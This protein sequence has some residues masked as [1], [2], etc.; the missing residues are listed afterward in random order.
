MLSV[1][2]I[3]GIAAYFGATVTAATP[4]AAQ[5]SLFGTSLSVAG[6]ADIRDRA[7]VRVRTV[8]PDLALIPQ[9]AAQTND[10]AGLPHFNLDLFPGVEFDAEVLHAEAIAGGGTTLFVRL[11]GVEL[12]NA[13]LVQQ[14]DVIMG[15][16][17]LPGGAYSI[18]GQ[19]DGTLRIAEVAQHLLPPELEP[20]TVK[21]APPTAADES[22]AADVP[23]DTGRLIDVMVVYTPSAVSAVGGASAMTALAN[24]AVAET[25]QAYMNSG[26]AQR[27]R[28]VYQAQVSYTEN[29][30][31][32][33]AFS[34]GLTALSS[35]SIANVATWRN[36]YGADEVVMLINDGT[37]CG[38]AYLPSTISSANSGQGFAVVAWNCATGYYSFAH[39][40]G[41]NMGAHHD[42]FVLNAGP[43]PDLLEKG[44]FCYSRG[45]SH[46]GATA[47][48]SWRS[49]M[50]YNN[51]CAAKVG[52]CTRIQYFSDPM[53]KYSD[54]NVMGDGP[55]RNN[56]LTL[57]KS[58]NAVSN[59][60]ATT[61]AIAASFT[62][63]PLADP[64][65]GYIEFMK[66]GGYTGGCTATTYCPTATITRGQAAVFLERT[67][68]GA[69]FSRTPTGTA[70]VDV[71]VSTPFAGFIEQLAAD[72]I[73]S[74]C[75]ATHFCPADPVVR[76]AMVKFILKAKCGAAYVPATPGSS[77]FADVPAGDPFLPWIYK[78]YTLGI[79]SGCA[80]GPLIFC[81]A[82]YV[83]R[84]AMAKFINTAFPFGEPSEACTP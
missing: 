37:Y 25:N 60:R 11:V 19:A 14:G 27:V 3:G 10:Y 84:A 2:A 20:V 32:N 18:R 43:C 17:T 47:G 69:L 35:G 26:I 63:V 58:A 52:N 34:N 23:A 31:G 72:N 28:L 49:I 22:I 53:V 73:T 80:T 68:R 82:N 64:F 21:G 55:A 67:K 46:I 83:T 57:N 33:G 62:D 81:P 1:I 45:I 13:V 41:H 66:Q 36:T 39:E 15:S 78:A 71:T 48:Q 9:L 61:Q 4:A 6:A 40:M 16:V 51:E 54:G 24:L 77:P 42:P 5:P 75:D 38:I 79:T 44:A 56:A 65:F 59:Y 76:A 30:G 50:A 7:E 12:G 29:T 74:G 70:F 8:R